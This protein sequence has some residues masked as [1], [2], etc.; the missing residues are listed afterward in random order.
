L[1]LAYALGLA[2]LSASQYANFAQAAIVRG[3]ER[4]TMASAAIAA[5]TGEGCKLERSLFYE[6]EPAAG[7]LPIPGTDPFTEPVTSGLRAWRAHPTQPDRLETGWFALPDEVRDG[8]W[9]LVIPASGIDEEHRVRVEYDDGSGRA[10]T[11]TRKTLATS[12]LSDIRLHPAATVTRFRILAESDGPVS[13]GEE[14]DAARDFVV[15]QPRVP[16]TEPLVELAQRERIAVAWNLAFFAPCLD[17]PRQAHGRVEIA[18]YVL[19]DSEQPGNMSYHSRS[20]GPFAGVLGLTEP[21]RVPVYAESDYGEAEMSALDL[22]RLVPG[23][24]VAHRLDVELGT[25]VRGGM[26]RVPTVP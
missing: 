2:I 17:T 24:A 9:P 20:G 3:P 21:S 10:L 6:P 19:S 1:A 13:P 22:V 15:A 26:D 16:R 25:R 5:I 18:D 14:P 8:R 7:V 12:Q 11:P 4:Y 23:D